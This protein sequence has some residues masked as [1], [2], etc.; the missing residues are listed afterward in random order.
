M[1]FWIFLCIS[2]YYFCY[3]EPKKKAKKAKKEFYKE[4]IPIYG[5]WVISNSS[6]GVD[7]KTLNFLKEVVK[8]T[9]DLNSKISDNIDLM[10]IRRYAQEVLSKGGI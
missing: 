3:V 2:L 9:D 4:D 1:V 5:D 10:N 8:A 7:Q 6:I